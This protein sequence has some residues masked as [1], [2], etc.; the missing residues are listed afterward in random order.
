MV[1]LAV[2][3]LG[4]NAYGVPI[5]RELERCTGREAG[6][7]SVYAALDRLEEK[8]LLVSKLGEPTASRGGRAKRYFEQC[9]ATDPT[10][11]I[12]WGTAGEFLADLNREL[13][14]FLAVNPHAAAASAADT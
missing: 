5:S 14:R 1:L 2:I 10:I 12:Y 4:D 13:A 3:R 6:F 8:G 11:N 7:G 9:F